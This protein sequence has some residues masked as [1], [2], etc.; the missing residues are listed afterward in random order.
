MDYDQSGIAAVY[1]EARALTE[2]TLRTWLDLLSKHIDREKVLLIVDLGC[3]TGRSSEPW[4]GKVQ[5]RGVGIDPSRKMRDHRG[6][7]LMDVGVAL[8][9]P[10]AE[11]IPVPDRAT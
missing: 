11:V 2:E 10:S 3:G 4:A 6:S 1:D 8:V 9:L 5:A 7:K